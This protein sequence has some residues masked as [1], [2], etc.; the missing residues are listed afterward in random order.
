VLVSALPGCWS[1][2]INSSNSW[3]TSSCR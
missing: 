3:V 1:R 2:S